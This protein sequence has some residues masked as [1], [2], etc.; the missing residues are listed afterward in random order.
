MPES[1][2][3]PSSLT[4]YVLVWCEDLLQDLPATARTDLARA[5]STMHEGGPW[6]TRLRIQ[7]LAEQVSGKYGG[8]NVFVGELHSERPGFV[9]MVAQKLSEPDPRTRGEALE[10]LARLPGSPELVGELDQ[11]GKHGRLSPAERAEVLRRA[12]S[13]PVLPD[14]VPAPAAYPDLPRDYPESYEEQKRRD[15]PYEPFLPRPDQTKDL[16]KLDEEWKAGLLEVQAY[17][18]AIFMIMNR[19]THPA[20]E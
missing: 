10:L 4:E 20:L 16:A 9:A 8:A 18:R 14:P 6:P 15:P 2:G 12:L 19:K 1:R 17:R 3:L 5:L 11:A 13:N 7:R